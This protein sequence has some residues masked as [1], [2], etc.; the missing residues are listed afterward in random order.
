MSR[1][2][3]DPRMIKA[4][5]TCSCSK[6][7]IK[8]VKGVNIYYWPSSREVFCMSCGEESYQQFL[9]SAA[10]ED[11]YNGCGNPYAN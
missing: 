3:N 6:C 9:S 8:L 2:A 1:Y 5:F 11:V 7:R 10:D 4:K